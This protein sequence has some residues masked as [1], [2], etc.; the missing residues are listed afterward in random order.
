MVTTCT[1][2]RKPGSRSCSHPRSTSADCPGRMSSSRGRPAA[3][4]Q[5]CEVHKNRHQVGWLTW[6]PGVFPDV[7]IDAED[8]NFDEVVG[9]V[10]DEL[11]AGVECDLIDKVPPHPK[12]GG[13][14]RHAY[15]VYRQALQDPAGDP[16][17][18]LGPVISA[19]QGY[20]EDFPRTRRGCAQESR[21]SHVQPS[22]ESNDGRSTSR[23]GMGH[24]ASPAARSPGRRW[25][26]PPVRRR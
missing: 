11:A 21:D 14:S 2:R 6:F 20:L 19:G 13:G 5:G 3:V 18:E 23:R 12:C 25:A 24:V 22:G 8:T 10:I 26:R 4:V 15:P 9:V 17:G 7:F 16:V 1:W